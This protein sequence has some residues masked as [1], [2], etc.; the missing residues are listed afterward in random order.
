MVDISS[1]YKGLLQSA[2][3]GIAIAEEKYVMIRDEVV[4][5]NK[6]N[7]L[8]WSM[9]TQENIQITGHNS[10][11]IRKGNETLKFQVVSPINVEIRT[12]STDPPND[13][14]DKNPG[15]K[16]IGFEVDLK[17]N[18]EVELIVLLVPE[19]TDVPIEINLDKIND[20]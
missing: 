16:M 15:T 17:P 20:W 19:G 3:R 1:C 18:Q 2:V 5:V 14:E 8:R 4:N 13:F 6:A 11:V 7:I 10:A 9:V 12:Y